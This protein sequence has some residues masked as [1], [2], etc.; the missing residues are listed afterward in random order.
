MHKNYIIPLDCN[1]LLQKKNLNVCSL[2]DSIKQNIHLILYTKFGEF[3][4]DLSYGCEI[5]DKNFE[6]IHSVSK[7]KDSINDSIL[8]SI[9]DNEIRLSN[10]KINVLL[11]DSKIQDHDTHMSGKYRMRIIIKIEGII[12]ETNQVFQHWENIF[13]SPLSMI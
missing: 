7:W 8:V 10:I 5:W 4:Y 6:N 2:E 3:R 1:A 11:K 12:N 13:F 9:Q